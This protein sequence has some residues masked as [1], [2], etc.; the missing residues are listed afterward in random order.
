MR[1]TFDMSVRD[2]VPPALLR[3]LK[4]TG[5]GFPLVYSTYEEALAACASS[6]YEDEQLV[7]VIREKTRRLR[8]ALRAPGP[9]GVNLTNFRTPLGI[10]LA[11]RGPVLRVIDYGG[12]CGAHYFTARK[13][14]D[15]DVKLIWNVVETPA[16]AAGAKDL[17]NEELRFFSDV[18]E[19][20]RHA[21]TV[22]LLFSSSTL[23]Y[24][25]DAYGTLAALVGRRAERVFL[26][27]LGLGL[28][29]REVVCV[30]RS[31][32]STNGPGPL[33]SGFTDR[34]V[35][36]PMTAMAKESVERII[37]TE[38]EIR[39]AFEEDKGAYW[40]DGRPIDLYGY[41]AVRRPA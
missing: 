30:Q 21:G 28:G 4:K 15:T 13:L 38:Y 34:E 2:L 22:D 32:L 10:A 7:A 33:P 36:Y 18:D 11:C 8:D 23:Q 37:G 40:P 16:M 5:G 1:I 31:R 14:L 39:I 25:P 19:A 41:F 27:R 12:A 24:V 9:L 20:W 17:E 26:T 3:A 29:A 35:R 6:G